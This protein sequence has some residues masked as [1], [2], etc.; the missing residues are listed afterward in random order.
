MKLCKKDTQ[1]FKSNSIQFESGNLET[2]K[3]LVEQDFGITLLPYLSLQSYHPQCANGVI[4]TFEEPVPR[5][6]IRLVHARAYLKEHHIRALY[7]C[8]QECLPEELKGI[9]EENLVH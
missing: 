4:K 9:E 8:I 2:L 3:K 5:R 7:E 1:R 6:K